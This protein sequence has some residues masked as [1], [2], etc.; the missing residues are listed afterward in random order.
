MSPTFFRRFFAGAGVAL[1]LCLAG[2]APAVSS[3]AAPQPAQAAVQHTHPAL[4]RAQDTDTTIYFFGT[5][6][7][8]KQ[9]AQWHF[10]AL[11][12]ALD[13]SDTLYMEAANINPATLRPLVMQYGLDPANP[14]SAKLS[15]E[16]NA[17]LKQAVKQLG[18]PGGMAA[19]NMMKPWLA[20]ITVATAPIIKAGYDPKLGVDKQ[21]EKQFKAAGKPVEGFET[22]K[23]QLMFLVNLPESVQLKF[24]QKNL[25]DYT[26]ADEQINK[27]VRIWQHG[28][29][30]ALGTLIV[31]ELKD[32]SPTLYQALILNRNK[33]WSRQIAKLMETKPGTIFVAVGS[34]HLAGPDRLQVQLEKLGIHTT[35]IAD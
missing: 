17:V 26:E 18:I 12:K 6:H 11:D 20:A 21:L 5:V 30:H 28:K 34:G 23:Q 16:E 10:P 25:H 1:A 13:A 3:Q 24:L 4:W 19:I 14:L 15:K 8:M 33:N 31:A 32:R 29:V 35:R 22:A 27:I 2:C 9:G 7:A